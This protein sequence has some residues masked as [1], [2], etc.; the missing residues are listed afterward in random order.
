MMVHKGAKFGHQRRPIQT[1]PASQ[2]SDAADMAELERKVDELIALVPRVFFRRTTTTGN[3]NSGRR[4]RPWFLRDSSNDEDTIVGGR[5]PPRRHP[6]PA[7]WF[8][9]GPF[10]SS[11]NG[12]TQASEPSGFV[13]CRSGAGGLGHSYYFS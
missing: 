12:L 4:H 1:T 13:T 10:N 7:S 8:N 3:Q 11:W 2:T 5:I 6:S 9:S